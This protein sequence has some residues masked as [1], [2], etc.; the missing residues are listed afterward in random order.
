MT[1]PQDTQGLW[2]FNNFMN[3]LSVFTLSNGTISSFSVNAI[4][5]LLVHHCSASTITMHPSVAC[6]YPDPTGPFATMLAAAS[7]LL[8][9]LEQSTGHN[10]ILSYHQTS[11]SLNYP[12]QALYAQPR[13]FLTFCNLLRGSQRKHLELSMPKLRFACHE[14][15]ETYILKFCG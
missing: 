3:S 6:C 9:C 10:Q 7:T 11:I 15:T 8:N 2:T 4:L 12:D 14:W 13:H 5:A 1:G